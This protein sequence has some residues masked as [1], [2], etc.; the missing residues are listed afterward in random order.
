MRAMTHAMPGT[1]A[2]PCGSGLAHARCCG[3]L[4]DG[5]ADAADAGQLM[6]SRYSAYVRGAVDYLLATWHLS[7]RPPSLDL[8]PGVRWLGLVV[9]QHEQSDVDT[10][11]VEF[12]A[13]YRIGG[14]P[15]VP[16]HEIS[17]FVREDGRWFYLDGS[18]PDA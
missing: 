14:A 13:R 9:K 6:R 7:T 18:F 5:A 1:T 11:V 2:C 17:R 15:A 3:P 12:V 10:A 4:H 8:D 16:L